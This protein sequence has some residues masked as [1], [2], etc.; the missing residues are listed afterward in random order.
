MPAPGVVAETLEAEVAALTVELTQLLEGG[1]IEELAPKS[2]L[3]EARAK[4]Q[5]LKY[6]LG[7]LKRFAAEGGGGGAMA[8]KQG[9]KSGAKASKGAGAGAVAQGAGVGV[10]PSGTATS[11]MGA[12]PSTD[13]RQW[14][15][16]Q[17]HEKKLRAIG[18]I[19]SNRAA[20]KGLSPPKWTPEVSF[21]AT[22]AAAAAAATRAAELAK[23]AGALADHIEALAQASSA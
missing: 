13:A 10:A 15:Q 4:N 12:V 18:F 6:Q 17:L 8:A 5:K 16:A 21:A 3:A 23:E 1:S 19:D 2:A 9:K 11:A 7:H 14:I 22:E 20:R